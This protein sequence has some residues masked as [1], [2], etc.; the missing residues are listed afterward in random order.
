MKVSINR[1]L[2]VSCGS[3]WDSCP[4]LFEEDPGDSFS[5]ITEQ[6]R[7]GGNAAEGVPPEDLE[8]CARDAADLC[9]AQIITIVD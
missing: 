8:G 6:Y 1:A 5:R 4:G 9:P 7:V 2:C 3:C